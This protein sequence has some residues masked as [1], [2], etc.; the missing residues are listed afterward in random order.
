[1]DWQIG[2][3]VPYLGLPFKVWLNDGSVRATKYVRTMM[4]PML[5][6]IDC[7]HPL[8]NVVCDPENVRGWR[9]A[10]PPGDG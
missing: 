1:M 2:N 7:T 3:R 8:Q 4:G 6:F 5:H 9:L 10:T